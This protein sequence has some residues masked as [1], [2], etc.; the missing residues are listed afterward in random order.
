MEQGYIRF[1]L[2]A[3]A[4]LLA[5]LSP[6]AVHAATTEAAPGQV[7]LAAGPPPAPVAPPARSQRLNPTGRPIMLTVPARDGAAYLGDVPLTIGADDSLSFPAS[8]V[9]QLLGDVLNPKILDAL[10]ANLAGKE[11]VGPGDFASTGLGVEYDPRTLELHF[12]I[13]VEMRASRRISVSALDRSSI[14]KFER[15]A[16]FSAYLNVRGS[17]DLVESGPSTGF[18]PPVFLLNGASRIGDVVAESDAI[19]TPGGS[20]SDFQ[21]IGSRLVYDD[22]KDLIRFT[23]GDLQTQSRGFQTSPDIAGLSIFRSYS[24]LNPQQIIRPRG[25][26]TFTL[27]RPSTVEV[28]VNGEQV[29]RLQL[30]PGNY[31]LRD[32]PFAQGANDIRLNVLDDTGRTEVLRFNM[33]IDQTQLA[34][35]LSEFGLYAGVKAPLG[36]SGPHYTDQLIM[37]GF[38]RRGISD[39]LTLGTNFQADGNVQMGGAEAV[40]GTPFGTI[41]T[42]IAYSHTRGLGDGLAV[43]ANFQRL[44]QHNDGQADTLNFFAEHRSRHFAPVTFFLAENPYKYEVGASYTHAFNPRF[45]AGFDAR[46]SKGRDTNPDLHNYRLIAG[47]R[48]SPT[49]SMT[50]EA[51]YQEDSRGKDFSGFLTLTV[52]LGQSSSVRTEYDSRDNRIRT[53]YQM[54]HGSAVGSY[55]VTADVERSDYG[56]DYSVNANYFTN[57]AELGVSQFGTFTRDFGSDLSQRTNFR[58]GTSIALADGAV[59][60]GRPIYDSFAIVEPHKSLDKTNVVVDPS[61]FGFSADSGS[62]GAATMP[63]LSSYAERTVTVDTPNA[64]PG[65]DI[66]QGSF[67]L[68]P[69]YRS[70][71]KL[72]VGSDYHYTAIGTMLDIDGDPVSLV[73]GKATE[74]AHP[75]NPPVTMFTNRQGRFGA[76]GLA[77]GNWRL[78]M[79]DQKK[80]VYEITIPK[81]AK[82]VVELGTI[83]PIGK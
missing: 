61:P 57:R 65:V 67:K 19:W 31:N 51:R 82:G 14:G 72:V 34:K 81:D 53:S 79:L 8:R 41:G 21:R 62:L 50:A 30:A 64:A 6:V 40:I 55:N 26:Q 58:V 23:A 17:F 13:P 37:S 18:N 45:Y 44:I 35:G 5:L 12:R 27:E 68:F 9:L 42:S 3:G 38:Y 80:S 76:T 39:A 54:L 2:L 78:E 75:D 69:G 83:R 70:G 16:D 10:R 28:L 22:M 66:G 47:W 32:F 73:A 71:Y 74:L 59:S 43:Q 46:F 60:V 4:S 77:P 24:V 15:S 11:T 33:F 52:R 48:L 25:D 20:G 1:D 29:R 49:A 63:S 7:M 56:S 36:L